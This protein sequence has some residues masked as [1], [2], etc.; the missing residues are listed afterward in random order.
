VK[1]FTIGTDG[2]IATFEGGKDAGALA[3]GTQSFR[4]DRELGDIT[5]AWRLDRLEE[6]WNRLSGV[7]KVKRFRDRK[8]AVA[9]IWKAV[10]NLKPS[11]VKREA[12]SP[13][14]DSENEA[15]EV[16]SR[17]DDYAHCAGDSNVGPARRSD[18]KVHNLC[19]GLAG[20]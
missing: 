18:L 16:R 15:A 3:A 7:Q 19:Y 12:L 14:G 6:V 5:A 17:P 13:Q 1:T 9:R 20:T 2:D 8:T 11:S 4:S 10:Q